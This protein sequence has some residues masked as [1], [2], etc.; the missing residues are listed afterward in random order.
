MSVAE[1]KRRGRRTKHEEALE[2]L[3]SIG[4]DIGEIPELEFEIPDPEQMLEE[5]KEKLYREMKSGNLTSTALVN[6]LK[7]VASI[8]EAHRLAM[9]V[10]VEPVERDVDEILGDVGLPRDRRVDIGREEIDRLRSK[11]VA[12]ELVVAQIEGEA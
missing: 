1:P 3:K 4:K 5:F 11:T 8:A 9:Q 2:Y 10:G 7:A 12:L 6:G